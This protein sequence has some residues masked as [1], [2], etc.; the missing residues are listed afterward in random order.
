[1]RSTSEKGYEPSIDRANLY[2]VEMSEAKEVAESMGEKG[3]AW[4]EK[5]RKML[6]MGGGKVQKVRDEG[7]SAV[8][9]MSHPWGINMGTLKVPMKALRV[10][11]NIPPMQMV[12][13]WTDAYGKPVNPGDIKVP[14]SR[15]VE[16]GAPVASEQTQEPLRGRPDYGEIEMEIEK[17]MGQIA[18]IIASSYL[19]EEEAAMPEEAHQL[20]DTQA[21]LFKQAEEADKQMRVWLEEVSKKLALRHYHQISYGCPKV[22]FDDEGAILITTPTKKIERSVEKV[23]GDYKGDWSKL[24]DIVRATIGVDNIGEV[25]GVMGVLRESGMVLAR[26]PKDKLTNPDRF[27]F[28]NI[29]MNIRLPNGH[30]GELQINL[31]SILKVREEMHKYYEMVRE[32]E[33]E[34][35]KGGKDLSVEEK[36]VVGDLVELLLK[37]YTD[38]WTKAGG[39]KVAAERMPRNLGDINRELKRHGVRLVKGSG[40]YYP[41]SEIRGGV[42]S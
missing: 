2:K 20:V 14:Y 40:Y 11:G 16:Y 17:R 25:D 15:P 29:H 7:G 3:E 27:G 21:E 39:V 37:K 34:A 22:D 42:G 33:A 6:K 41:I 12:Q 30:I 1:M 8:V 23:N 9:T 35:E 24:L 13:P 38:A 10:A 4:L 31:K 28:R 32:V 26:R 36:V 18:S 5:L 19:T